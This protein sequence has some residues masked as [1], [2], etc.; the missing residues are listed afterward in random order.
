MAT[1]GS[2]FLTLADWV[3]RIDPDGQQANI[4]ESLNETNEILDDMIF[5]EGNLTTGHRTTIRTGL[6]SVTWRKLNYGVARSKSRT[7]QVD[8]T[9]GLCEAASEVDEELAALNG[10]KASFLMSEEKPFVEAMSQE[11]AGGLFYFDTDVNPEKF[12]GLAERYPNLAT[13]NVV[14]AGGTGSDLTSVWLVTWGPQTA[15]GIFPKG[16]T[17]G[18]SR[19]YKGLVR[20][21]DDQGNP[22]WAHSSQYKWKIGLCV[23]DWRYIVRICNVETGGA[24]NIIDHEL[25]IRALGKLP[26]IRTGAEN[27]MAF[28]MHKDVWTDFQILAI[29]KPNAGLSWT[30]LY[31]QRVLSFWGVPFRQV[32]QL[33]IT[34]DALT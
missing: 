34:E 33:L 22:Y 26:S 32:D 9:I 18:L 21:T 19:E 5:T 2:D 6:P 30:E 27:R 12:L 8:D 24:T 20:V 14:D 16:S 13:S 31:G 17:A 11:M 7:A 10:N 28:Y 15:F 1:I 29:D 4:V 25:L 23:R 3:K